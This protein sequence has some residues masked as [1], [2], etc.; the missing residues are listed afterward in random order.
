MPAP[1]QQM[2]ALSYIAVT[3]AKMEF[4]GRA[5]E[6]FG[7]VKGAIENKIVTSTARNRT[8]TAVS[9]RI[10]SFLAVI[11]LPERECG[12]T[13]S[14]ASQ[15]RCVNACGRLSTCPQFRVRRRQSKDRCDV[16]GMSGVGN[17]RND[18]HPDCGRCV[19]GSGAPLRK[20]SAMR[21]AG[22]EQC[23]FGRACAIWMG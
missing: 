12:H 23:V 18:R 8:V 20:G 10:R 14:V 16:S 4:S 21:H 9:H 13:R 19:E 7:R 15:S 3:A 22:A 1:F 5:H 17:T 11:A 2:C 6:C